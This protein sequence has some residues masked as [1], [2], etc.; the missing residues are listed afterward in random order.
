MTAQKL[1]EL[2][3]M[4]SEADRE[5]IEVTVIEEYEALLQSEYINE[6]IIISGYADKRRAKLIKELVLCK[7]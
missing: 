2:L 3:L 6:A 5:E 1:F 7:A 4:V